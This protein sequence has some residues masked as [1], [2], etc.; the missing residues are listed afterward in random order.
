MKD[1]KQLIIYAIMSFGVI[2]L[3]IKMS[4]VEELN[5]SIIVTT[6]ILF[7]VVLPIFI[8][9]RMAKKEKEREHQQ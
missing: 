3:L 8:A 5:S 7:V 6:A 2:I 1:I 9:I 4:K